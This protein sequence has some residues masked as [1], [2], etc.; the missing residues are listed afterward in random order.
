VLLQA[1]VVTRSLTKHPP[2]HI[3][4]TEAQIPESTPMEVI[5]QQSGRKLCVRGGIGSMRS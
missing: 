3:R 5:G 2:F 1:Q 4:K